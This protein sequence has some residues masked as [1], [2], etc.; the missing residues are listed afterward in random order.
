MTPRSGNTRKKFR[1][2]IK[3]GGA[4]ATVLL[5]VVWVGSAW[6]ALD[7]D[8]GANHCW[9]IAQG[10][11]GATRLD[12]PRPPREPMWGS[13][14]LS[15]RDRALYFKWWPSAYAD[16]VASI[17]SI[18]IWLFIVPLSVAVAAAWRI[19]ARAMQHLRTSSCLGCNYPRHGLPAAAVCPECGSPPAATDYS[20]SSTG[21]GGG[22]T[23]PVPPSATS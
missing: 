14:F 23:S 22:A 1:K 9:W 20:S 11:I 10:S 16:T 2:A 4:A 18:P 3:W 15:L 19:D 6:C 12:I 8:D 5:V 17:V 21:A 13:T 7:W